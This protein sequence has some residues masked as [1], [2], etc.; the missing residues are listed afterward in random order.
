MRYAKTKHRTFVTYAGGERRLADPRH[1]VF[2][3]A[4]SV[5]V[6]QPGWAWPVKWVTPDEIK[7]MYGSDRSETASNG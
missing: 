7:Q 4:T 5:R 2:V 3:R 6:V 1:R